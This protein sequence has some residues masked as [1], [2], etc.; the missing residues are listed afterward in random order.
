MSYPDYLH[1]VLDDENDVVMSKL[2]P[3]IHSDTGIFYDSVM[4]VKESTVEKL[5]SHI[6]KVNDE[7]A[8]L[9]DKLAIAMAMAM[10]LAMAN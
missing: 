7:N 10:A 4:Y 6:S 3:F 2:E 9:K 1:L 8:D 5:L